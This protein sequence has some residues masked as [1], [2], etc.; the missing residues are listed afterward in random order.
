MESRAGQPAL[1]PTDLG[2]RLLG[3]VGLVFLVIGL[4]DLSLGWYPPRFGD[5]EWEFGTVTRTLDSLPISVLGLAMAMA[6]SV[7][8][9]VTWAMRS[10]A[11]L[12]GILAACL[13]VAFVI[14]LLDIPVALRTV[15]DPVLRAG[16]DR[17]IVKAIVQGVLYPTVLATVGWR[18]V[19]AAG[20]AR[21]FG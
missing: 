13:V 17:A 14:F 2:W 9:R 8:R 10:A 18:G 16:L 15:T 6:S 21:T 4:L 12:C 19:R 3:W 1:P 11:L 7:Q 5:A 20:R